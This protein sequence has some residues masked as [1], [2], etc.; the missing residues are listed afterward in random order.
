MQKMGI[1]VQ[2]LH[3][4]NHNTISSNSYV[5]Y[6]GLRHERRFLY[7]VETYPL[8]THL[9]DILGVSDLSLIHTHSI[10]DKKKLMKPLLDP[11]KRLPF[12]QCYD[13]FVTSFC[14]PL[15]HSLAMGGNLFND[16]HQ[17]KNKISYRYQ[18]FP[19]IRVNRPG[20][21]SIGPHCDMAYGH[22][23]GNINFHIPLTPTKGTNALYTE[24]HPGREDWHPLKTKSIGLGYSF[25]GARNLHFT[26]E[27]TTDQSRVSIDFRI[28]IH[29]ETRKEIPRSIAKESIKM[30]MDYSEMMRD[31]IGEEED[32]RCNDIHDVLCHKKMLQDNYSSFPGY[33]EEAY[34][35]LGTPSSTKSGTGGFGPGPVV[36]KRN[37]TLMHPDR[38]VGFP[39]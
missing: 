33:Y 6:P 1:D 7:D 18:A 29:R 30:M 21:F 23:M 10:Q 27:N 38:R 11:K 24:S 25:D 31:A 5:P 37:T 34:V 8:H 12:H 26:L 17:R 13:N 36:C 19:C 32:E 35:E 16:Q 14:I 28:A 22:S 2:S 9:A 4:H 20:E 15:L 3:R 39:F